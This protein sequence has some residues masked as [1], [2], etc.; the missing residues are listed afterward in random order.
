MYDGDAVAHT[1]IADVTIGCLSSLIAP[2]LM[3]YSWTE[4][5]QKHKQ[6]TLDR[7]ILI[8]LAI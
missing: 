5:K 7:I 3:K 8:L 2:N 4:Y 1:R 6:V